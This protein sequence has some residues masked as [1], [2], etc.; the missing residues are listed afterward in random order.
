MPLKEIKGRLKVFW[1]D[2]QS[3]INN[4]IELEPVQQKKRIIERN[5]LPKPGNNG[6]CHIRPKGRNGSDKTPL[7]DGRMIAKQA[8]WLDKEIVSKIIT[9]ESKH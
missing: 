2:L 3:L 6:L 1:T 7:P 8:F 5:N 9:T 4:G